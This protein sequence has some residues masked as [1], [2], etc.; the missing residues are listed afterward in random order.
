MSYRTTILFL[1]IGT[2]CVVIAHD[3]LTEAPAGFTTPTLGLEIGPDGELTGKPGVQSVSNGIGE[4]P[5]DTFR[6][7]SGAI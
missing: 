3:F 2:G 7:G 4:P 6:S 5:G 1:V